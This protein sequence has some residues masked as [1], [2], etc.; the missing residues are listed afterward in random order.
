[1]PLTDAQIRRAKPTD[2]KTKLFDG[3]GLHVKVLPTGTKS[4]RWKCRYNGVERQMVLGTYPELG[5]A[6]AR[7]TRV[8]HAKVLR[9]GRDPRRRS[10]SPP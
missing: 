8:L 7:A 5:L 1:M 3:H 6:D 10:A 9:D 2:S 4:W